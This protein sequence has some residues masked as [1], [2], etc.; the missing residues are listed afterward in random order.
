MGILKQC[1]RGRV[2]DEVCFTHAIKVITKYK[3]VGTNHI[4]KLE[5]GNHSKKKINSRFP[6]A[7]RGV[8]QLGTFSYLN[9]FL[10]E[11]LPLF[12]IF[13]K[14]LE[15]LRRNVFVVIFVTL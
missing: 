8:G 9:K 6:I 11:G 12:Y 10:F 3:I 5:I 2:L 4:R 15:S 7:P 14:L 1:T 13:R